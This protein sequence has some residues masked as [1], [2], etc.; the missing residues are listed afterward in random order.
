MHTTSRNMVIL[1]P[2]SQVWEHTAK[3]KRCEECQS[4]HVQLAL[5]QLKRAE[6]QT[7]KRAKA[8]EEGE[9]SLSSSYALLSER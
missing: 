7:N 1:S 4:C 5:W 6:Q 2:P 8:T 9:G 3:N